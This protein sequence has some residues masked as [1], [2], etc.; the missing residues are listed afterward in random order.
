M[1]SHHVSLECDFQQLLK[2]DLL[3]HVWSLMARFF[4]K[5]VFYKLL[6]PITYRGVKKNKM[7]NFTPQNS[8]YPFKG[9][10]GGAV[11]NMFSAMCA[12]SMYSR[13]CMIMSSFLSMRAWAMPRTSYHVE[14]HFRFRRLVSFSV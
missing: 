6:Q 12:L 11:G 9:R 7:W 5:T 3:P 13:L 4:Y 10:I 8:C 1:I 14:F 2:N